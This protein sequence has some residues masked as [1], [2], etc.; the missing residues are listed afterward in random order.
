VYPQQQPMVYPQQQ[1]MVYPQ[2]Q[3]VSRMPFWGKPRRTNKS[4]AQK[5]SALEVELRRD[6]RNMVSSPI[7]LIMAILYTFALIVNF[8]TISDTIDFLSDAIYPVRQM[9]GFVFLGVLLGL[10]PSVLIVIGLWLTYAE[11]FKK[12]SPTVNTAGLSMIRIAHTVTVIAIAVVALLLFFVSC[13]EGGFGFGFGLILAIAA[14]IVY[15]AMNIKIVGN[16]VDILD[17]A[18]PHTS[19][20]IVLAVFRIIVLC[21]G[22]FAAVLS[23]EFGISLLISIVSQVLAIVMLFIYRAKME[24]MEMKFDSMF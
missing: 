10:T 15:Y 19:G 12:D 16:S 13:T 7:M 18:V 22:V 17:V 8:I 9:G 20:I 2:Q 14:V 6:W 24:S 4:I 1:P 21:G 3:P 23:E 11:G 5:K